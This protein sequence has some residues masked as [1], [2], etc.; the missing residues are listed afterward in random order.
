MEKER[1]RTTR[2]SARSMASAMW[3]LNELMQGGLKVRIELKNGT[4]LSDEWFGELSRLLETTP[5]GRLSV[6]STTFGPSGHSRAVELCGNSVHNHNEGW[7]LTP[8]ST[9]GSCEFKTDRTSCGC[10]T[11]SC[12]AVELDSTFDTPPTLDPSQVE[13]LST[14]SREIPSGQPLTPGRAGAHY[15]RSALRLGSMV[16]TLRTQLK[17][18]D[19][20]EH[21]SRALEESLVALASSSRELKRLALS[22]VRQ[23]EG[24]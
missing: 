20:K 16:K 14:L 22:L 2:L 1:K 17:R 19:L 15:L 13:M 3:S 6:C 23:K 12:S 10:S 4:R 21:Q 24:S 8:S 11:G 18:Y 7:V 5:T 9:A